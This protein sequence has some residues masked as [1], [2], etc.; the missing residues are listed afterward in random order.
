M[1]SRLPRHRRSNTLT[2]TREDARAGRRS[3]GRRARTRRRG[4]GTLGRAR[5]I[6]RER[7]VGHAGSTS[8]DRCLRRDCRVWLRAG[9]LR[10]EHVVDY[11]D[12]AVGDQDVGLQELGRV[13]VNVVPGVQDGDVLA[14]G[15]EELGAVGQAGR[16][17]DLVNG[18]VVHDLGDLV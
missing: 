13:D 17:D 11:V 18:V 2:T 12:D 16:V 14:L 10:V 7:Q 4:N 1:E 9:T 8:V 3:L 5:D 6:A 15:A